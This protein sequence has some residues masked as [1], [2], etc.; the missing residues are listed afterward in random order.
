VTVREVFAGQQM[1]A[2]SRTPYW[3]RNG[4]VEELFTL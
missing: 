3:M 4:Y 1:F 2:H